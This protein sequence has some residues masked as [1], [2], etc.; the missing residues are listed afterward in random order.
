MSLCNINGV[1]NLQ[2]A[3][4]AVVYWKVATLGENCFRNMCKSFITWDEC[5]EAQCCVGKLF[6]T[7]LKTV[8]PNV[9]VI[10]VICWCIF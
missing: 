5:N 3:R 8:C 9:V 4:F 7:V 2:S 1:P 10:I 6:C